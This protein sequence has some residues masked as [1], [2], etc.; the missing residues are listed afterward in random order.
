MNFPKLYTSTSET[1]SPVIVDAG[2]E[3]ENLLGQFIP[4]HY[5]YNMLQDEDR[6][7]AF[8]DAIELCIRPGSTV[9]ELGGGTGILSSLA[10]R[11]GAT[12]TCVEHNPELVHTATNFIAANGLSDL[13]EVI[14]ADAMSFVPASK[15]DFVICEML[16]VGLLRE[17][18]AQVI[19]AFKQN[20][21][22]A[23]GLPLPKFLPEAS[24]LMM[25]P[26]QHSFDYRG[27]YAPTV[28]FQAPMLE[29][30]RTQ[31]LGPLMPYSNIDYHDMIPMQFN[32]SQTLELDRDGTCN[33]IRFITQNIIAV[34]MQHQHAITWPNQCLV[35]PLSESF[36]VTAKD[37]AYICFDYQAGGSLNELQ[38][39]LRVKL[40][41][42]VIPKR[43]RSANRCAI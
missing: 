1:F 22:K 34:D 33:A 17:K 4:L 39:S 30:S 40:K 24:I 29:Q 5:H 27:Y 42:S 3:H 38:S 20:Y 35:M 28:V 26:V 6:V 23:H 10:A 36:D 7:G 16:H 12:V 8:S 14:Q 11:C 2:P 13:V 9:V 32:V 21:L 37:R 43:P 19:A 31:P 15:V 18:Q 25:Q 41:L